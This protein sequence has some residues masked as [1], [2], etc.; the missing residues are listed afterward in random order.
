MLSEQVHLL[1]VFK[2]SKLETTL[3]SSKARPKVTAALSHR[4]LAIKRGRL[5]LRS[6]IR[7]LRSPF[8]AVPKGAHLIHPSRW[9]QP[10]EMSLVST[11]PLVSSLSK[12]RFL[13]RFRPLKWDP[14]SS[15][16]PVSPARGKVK[17]KG[18]RHNHPLRQFD[19]VATFIRSLPVA[20]STSLDESLPLIQV[21]MISFIKRQRRRR[22]M[23]RCRFRPYNFLG[24]GVIKATRPSFFTS[25]LSS[26]LISRKRLISYPRS[27][28]FRRSLVTHS[29]E[30]RFQ[31]KIVQLVK[32][33]RHR[34]RFKSVNLFVRRSK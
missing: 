21:P 11:F 9:W 33:A 29:N 12:T 14:R 32:L 18:F 16:F 27:R 31:R 20:F 3:I 5:A 7:R 2:L 15:E 30:V 34:K 22:R 17:V 13:R 4:S 8:A 23:R 6:S 10:V 26:N 25:L 19:P 28:Y 1:T 24:L